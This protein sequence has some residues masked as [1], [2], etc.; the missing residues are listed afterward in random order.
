M[1]KNHIIIAKITALFGIKGQVKIISYCE[2][3]T[4]LEKYAKN[5]KI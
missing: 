1:S 5:N 3:A 2:K 4:D